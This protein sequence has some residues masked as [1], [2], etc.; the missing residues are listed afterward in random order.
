MEEVKFVSLFPELNNKIIN[1]TQQNKEVKNIF[2]TKKNLKKVPINIL[3]NN[4]DFNFQNKRV[5]TDFFKKKLNF[6]LLKQL[7][8]QG[9][10]QIK[11]IFFQI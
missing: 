6:F 5:E 8:T 4:E 11:Q 2:K 9:K 1:R 7:I 10:L 3:L